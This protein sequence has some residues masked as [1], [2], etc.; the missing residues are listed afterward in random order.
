MSR[1]TI[2]QVTQTLP[3]NGPRRLSAGKSEGLICVGFREWVQ[4]RYCGA[5]LDDIRLTINFREGEGAAMC[6]KL[7]R[8]GL[9]LG[10]AVICAAIAPVASADFQLMDMDFV[11]VGNAGNAGMGRSAHVTTT[12]GFGAVGYEYLMGKYEV[13]AGQYTEFLNAVAKSDPNNLW[14]PNMATDSYGRACGIV[15]Q[16]VDGSYVYSV[17]GDLANRPVNYVS[18]W[19]AARFAN[20]LHNGKPTGAQGLG[21]TEAGAYVN[22]GN[23]ATFARTENAQFFIPNHHEW[24]KAA[25]HNNSGM[26]GDDYYLYPTRTDNAPSNQLSSPDPGNSAN[27]LD[28]DY[29]IGYP[30]YRTEVGAFGSSASA[31]GTFDQG[32][33]IAE[34]TESSFYGS[35]RAVFGGSCEQPVW[36]LHAQ[37]LATKVPDY[38]YFEQGFRVAAAYSYVIPEPGSATLLLLA[39][40]A[41]LLWRR[42]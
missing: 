17:A 25:F 39:A 22:I 41:G 1:M 35:E 10:A 32:G 30:Y 33:N 23:Q 12:L 7:L 38:R 6:Q 21:T 37:E 26:T 3:K 15:R 36:L 19:D 16:G 34:W 24:Y 40:V 8:F 5:A 2:I 27:F 11:L 29:T 28:A 31:Y 20:W 18:L 13:T 9:V 42:R 14:N 4:C